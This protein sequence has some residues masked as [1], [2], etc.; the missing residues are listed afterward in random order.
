[1]GAALFH[2]IWPHLRLPF[3]LQ[4]GGRLTFKHAI[5]SAEP[6]FSVM[7]SSFLLDTYPLAVWLS[8]LPGVFECYHQSDL[9]NVNELNESIRLDHY[10]LVA[11]L[12]SGRRVD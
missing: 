3:I 1:M 2:T 5:K 8:I 7:V 11:L 10:N 9:K 6:V 4:R 12:A